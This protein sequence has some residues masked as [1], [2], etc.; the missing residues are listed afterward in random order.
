M[1][2]TGMSIYNL[3]AQAFTPSAPDM[4]RLEFAA[5][6]TVQ[7][8]LARNAEPHGCF[9][10][11]EKARRCFFDEESTQLIGD[12]DAP[13]STGRELLAGDKAVVE[14]AMN[15]RWSETEDLCSLLDSGK[16]TGWCIGGQLEARDVAIAAETADLICGEALA[17]GSLATLTIENAGDD[18]VGVVYGQPSQ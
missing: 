11:G 4:D 15:S 2:K 17:V 7:D 13:G 6:Y 8:R 9:E 5:L 16:L 14:P 10:H 3:D 18:L 1:K 12:A